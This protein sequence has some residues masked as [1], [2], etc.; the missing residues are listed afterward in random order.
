MGDRVDERVVLFITTDF[1][2]HEDGVEQDAAADHQHQQDPEHQQDAMPPVQE[3]VADVE[4]QQDGDQPD[5]E[6]DMAGDGSAAP[7]EFHD[8]RLARPGGRQESSSKTC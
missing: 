8:S 2:H 7:G 3:K 5:A 1:T 4:N 6:G